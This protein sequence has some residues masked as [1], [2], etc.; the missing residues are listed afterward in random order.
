MVMKKQEMKELC[1]VEIAVAASKG[2]IGL[3]AS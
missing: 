1:M 2:G 3:L